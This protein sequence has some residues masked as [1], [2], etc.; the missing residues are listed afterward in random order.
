MF[1]KAFQSDP[2]DRFQTAAELIERFGYLV[3]YE[4]PSAV[5]LGALA[6]RLSKHILRGSRQAR[7]L[8]FK[9]HVGDLHSAIQTSI[10]TCNQRIRPFSLG[11]GGLRGAPPAL[12]KDVDLLHDSLVASL[13]Y[14]GHASARN[15]LFGFGAKGEECV[16]LR[17]FGS[18]KSDGNSQL[19]PWEAL[20]LYKSD[21]P[22]GKETLDKFLEE[23]VAI[24]MTRLSEEVKEAGS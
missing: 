23:A 21:S 10:N 16:L 9:G 1:E 18:T 3:R 24:A 22:P 15:I 2:P 17:T 8:Q 11:F 6:S 7:L 14:P 5:D 13:S 4:E 20:I 19:D 12:P